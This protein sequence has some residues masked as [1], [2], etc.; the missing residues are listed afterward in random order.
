MSIL[1][2]YTL[3]DFNYP[4]RKGFLEL[5]FV[6]SK[7]TESETFSKNN[8]RSSVELQIVFVSRTIFGRRV[9]PNRNREFFSIS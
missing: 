4:D 9:S 5:N 2:E 1:D 8:P 7:L 6:V 3:A